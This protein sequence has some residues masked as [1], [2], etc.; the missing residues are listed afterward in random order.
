MKTFSLFIVPMT[1]FALILSG[2]GTPHPSPEEVTREQ[3]QEKET[4]RAQANFFKE[5]P[6]PASKPGPD[7]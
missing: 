7:Q 4:A 5:S 1:I 6:P 2:C 3:Q